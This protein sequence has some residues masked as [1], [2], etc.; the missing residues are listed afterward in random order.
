MVEIDWNAVNTRELCKLFAEQ[1]R[2][3]NRPNTYLNSVGYAE[4]EKGMKDR[5]GI[6]VSKLQIKNKWD[7]LKEDFKAW[8]KLLLR[9]TGTGWCPIKGTIVMDDEWW[10]K[11]RAV[12]VEL[13]LTCCIFVFISGCIYVVFASFRTF[14][15]VENSGNKD[16]KMKRNYKCVL[17]ASLVLVQIIGL[18]IWRV[19]RKDKMAPMKKTQQR[20]QLILVKIAPMKGT[21]KRIHL[22][23]MK[24]AKEHQG[25]SKK[26]ARSR[27]Q[28]LH[29]SFKRQ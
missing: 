16:S 25:L 29:Y 11:A 8:K 24:M 27:K 18:R 21:H 1:V 12:S 10:K 14:Q 9:Q 23:S 22:L 26:K 6:E 15:A 4:V 2:R 19:L 5:L 13:L 28:G 20:V 3:G 7:K 17:V